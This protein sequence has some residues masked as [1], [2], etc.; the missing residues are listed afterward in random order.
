MNQIGVVLEAMG[1]PD[2]AAKEFRQA[3]AV[4]PRTIESYINL[5]QSAA[6]RGDFDDAVATY[7]SA[8]RAR[9]NAPEPRLALGLLLYRPEV[10]RLDEAADQLQKYLELVPSDADAHATLGFIYGE[11]ERYDDARRRVP[12]RLGARSGE[13]CRQSRGGA[14]AKRA[15]GEITRMIRAAGSASTL[16][17]QIQPDTPTL[18]NMESAVA[19]HALAA[20]D[21]AGR[22]CRAP[23]AREP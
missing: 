21:V 8:I 23:A 20:H 19:L 22:R 10:N 6:A 17:D 12:R 11:L 15:T 7:E 16:Y 5:A 2:E 13:P 9:P 4:D 1:K 14:S 3:I 18:A